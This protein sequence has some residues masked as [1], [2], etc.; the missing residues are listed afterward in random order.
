MHP[1]LIT[2]LPNAEHNLATAL[3]IFDLTP[4]MLQIWQ[5]LKTE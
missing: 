3:N 2:C 5:G 4:G 1:A